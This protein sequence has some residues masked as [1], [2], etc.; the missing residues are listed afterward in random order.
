MCLFGVRSDSVSSNQDG[1]TLR[2]LGSQELYDV[3]SSSSEQAAVLS[4][5]CIADYT[6]QEGE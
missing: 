4:D 6:H 2:E 3:P 5:A 1:V